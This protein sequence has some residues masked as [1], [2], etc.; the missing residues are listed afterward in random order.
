VAGAERPF[1]GVDEVAFER[2]DGFALV[3]LA[4][5]LA[6]IVGIGEIPGGVDGA[7]KSPILFECRG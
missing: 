1:V 7:S 4:R 5:D 3:E 2:V 6:P